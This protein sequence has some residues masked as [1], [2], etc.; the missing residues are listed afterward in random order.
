[1]SARSIAQKYAKALFDE[2][3]SQGNFERTAAELDT[4]RDVA[5]LQPEMVQFLHSPEVHTEEKLEFVSRVFASRVQPL[6]YNFLRLVIEKGRVQLLGPITEAFKELVDEHEGILH[7]KVVTAVPLRGEQER[8]LLAELG[9]ITRKRVAVEKTVDPA[10]LGGVVVHLGNKI[11]DRSLRR[12]LR[13]I[14]ERL[15]QVE[16]G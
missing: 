4:L 10:I 13:D 9:R 15:M 8:R 3:L 7:A 1:M 5:R 16:I 12:G 6:A 11:I 14:S 2:A